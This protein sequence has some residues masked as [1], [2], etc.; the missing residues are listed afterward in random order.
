MFNI[1][2]NTKSIS[3]IWTSNKQPYEKTINENLIKLFKPFIDCLLDN[4]KRKF[5]YNNP[6]IVKLMFVKLLPHSIIKTHIDRG[7]ILTL[8][9]RIHKPII[10]NKDVN[11]IINN[12]IFYMEPG[13]IYNFNNT[14]MHGV[15]NKSDVERVH[16]IIDYT[17]KS[18]EKK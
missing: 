8:S 18:V 3:L 11:V 2:K 14:L 15:N 16:C 17:D 1:H 12:K 6:V 5:N 10:T 7:Y 4:L 9:N 13:K